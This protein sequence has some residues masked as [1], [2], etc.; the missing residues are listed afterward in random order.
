M[1]HSIA[2]LWLHF[3][4]VINVKRSAGSMWVPASIYM[5]GRQC[6]LFCTFSATAYYESTVF[7]AGLF[8]P[9]RQYLPQNEA[10]LPQGNEKHDLGKIVR[11]LVL[12]S[13]CPKFRP[14]LLF[15]PEVRVQ[16]LK[17]H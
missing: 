11:F 10:I 3:V 15:A 9:P 17:N 14:F 1:Q 6:L 16:M 2:I 5:P 7:K 8:L 4:E 13:L 12:G